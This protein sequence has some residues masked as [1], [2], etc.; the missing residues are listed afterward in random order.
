MGAGVV[1]GWSRRKVQL[2]M[3]LAM[4]VAANFMLL[5]QLKLIP[6]GGDSL[7]LTGLRLAIGILGNCFLGALMT[8]GIGLYAPAMIMVALLGMTP[9]A[10]FPIMMGSCAFLMSTG[11]IRF[12]RARSYSFRP[13]LGLT[14]GGIPGVLVAAFLVESLP[15]DVIRW[16]VIAIVLYTALSMLGA[17][18]RE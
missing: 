6:G 14:L 2:G 16:G 7:G 18:A 9:K 12:I 15:L 4:L 17:L 5:S 3:G 13:A 11:S 8:L 1:A 10:A